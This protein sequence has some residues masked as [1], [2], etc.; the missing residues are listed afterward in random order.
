[1]RSTRSCS[2]DGRSRS[3]EEA[4]AEVDGHID[5]PNADAVELVEGHPLGQARVD[6]LARVTA[7]LHQVIRHRIAGVVVPTGSAVD[8]NVDPGP[9]V[10]EVPD[11]DGTVVDDLCR[12]PDAVKEGLELGGPPDALMGRRAVSAVRRIATRVA[13]RVFPLAA[14]RVGI[15]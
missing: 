6:R 9:V 1:E 14:P 15:W 7:G 5:A 4:G 3:G 11:L 10:A 12:A 8:A 2:P 13:A